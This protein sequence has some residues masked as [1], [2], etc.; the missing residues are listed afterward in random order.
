MEQNSPM[1]ATVSSD[2]TFYIESVP[3][4]RRDLGVEHDDTIGDD[5]FIT[6]N[7]GIIINYNT[8]KIQIPNLPPN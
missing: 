4:Y 6:A 7:L 5:F 2:D 8:Y 1:R 3:T